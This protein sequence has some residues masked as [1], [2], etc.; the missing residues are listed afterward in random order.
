MW[1][2]AKFSVVRVWL[3]RL[4]SNS[5]TTTV[6]AGIGLLAAILFSIKYR[7]NLLR[8]NGNLTTLQES[9]TITSHQH[10]SNT[11]NCQLTKTNAALGVLYVNLLTNTAYG[12]H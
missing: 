3:R 7:S 4:L 1:R 8:L 5:C 9:E 6:M 12:L 2:V 11:Q 10:T